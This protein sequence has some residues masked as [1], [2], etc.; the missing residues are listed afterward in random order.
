MCAHAKRM[1]AGI[2]SASAVH[3]GLFA[4]CLKYGLFD[5][6]LDGWAMVLPLPAHIWAAVKFDGE[7]KTSHDR[8]VPA[9]IA[10]PRSRSAV[11]IAGLPARWIMLGRMALALQAIVSASSITTPAVP[12][13][14]TISADSTR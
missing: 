13:A 1:D 6:A 14:A 4:R 12:L 11:G 2:G 9:A 10:L 7:R 5:G 8:R 3:E